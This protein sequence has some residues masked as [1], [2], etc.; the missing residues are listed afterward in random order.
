M[1]TRI[2]PL[3]SFSL[4]LL[5]AVFSCEKDP[6]DNIGPAASDFANANMSLYDETGPKIEQAV[7]L[8]LA[9]EQFKMALIHQTQELRTGDFEVLWSSFLDSSVEGQ[10]AIKDIFLDFAEG[11][12]TSDELDAFVDAYPS[13]I[14]ATRGSIESWLNETHVP[15]VVFVP[16]NFDEYAKTIQGSRAGEAV[17][18]NLEHQ[19]SDVVIALNISERHDKT[20]NPLIPPSYLLMNGIDDDEKKPGI[21][22]AQKYIPCPPNSLPEPTA[23]PPFTPDIVNF[24][25]E[26]LNG[27][28]F[29]SYDINNFPAELC[30]WGR[31]K[32]TRTSPSGSDVIIRYA[33]HDNFF[34]DPLPIDP[35]VTYQYSINAYIAFLSSAGPPSNGYYITC[36]A[37][38]NLQTTQ[39]TGPAFGAR[40]ESFIGEPIN[41]STIKYNWYPPNNMPI[42][43]YRLRVMTNSGY[44]TIA[45]LPSSATSYFY[46]APT[47]SRGLMTEVQ[48]Q[49]RSAGS[50]QGDFFDRSYL[51]FRQPNQALNFYGMR[52]DNLSAYEVGENPL[53]G[54][55]EVRL[56]ALRGTEEGEEGIIVA[57]SV[58]FMTN[59]PRQIRFGP[60]TFLTPGNMYRPISGPAQV[61]HAWDPFLPGSEIT[62]KTTETDQTEI[63]V[64]TQTTTN[65]TEHSLSTSVGAKAGV[66]ILGVEVG[67]EFALGW[68][69]KWS[70]KVTTVLNYPDDDIEIQ[71]DPIR[72]Y[73]ELV[74]PR[75]ILLYGL[76][77]GEGNVCEELNSLLGGE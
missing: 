21:D 22:M 14:I 69:S 71:V 65:S 76:L 32:I 60:F 37:T 8:A 61:M 63:T 3:V 56:V 31:I 75:G 53:N 62:I 52:V 34:Y 4:V 13:L 2:F 41:N 59:C 66:N 44:Q 23:C 64:S 16:S 45:E 15:A 40:I 73:E 27:G 17:T 29:I 74:Q 70:K 68:E 39:A 24:S 46:D 42:S 1:L 35:N 5:L 55:P 54:A 12:I 72:Y 25:A 43:E 9:N 36:P 51:P 6:V 20:G 11:L 49:A 7:S 19:F 38:N 58:I 18:V 50:W 77:S 10:E 33:H 48:I 47:S 30:T 67:T 26:P 28:I 57:N